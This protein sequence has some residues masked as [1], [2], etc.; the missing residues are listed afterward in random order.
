MLGKATHTI[1]IFSI[2]SIFTFTIL[3]GYPFLAQP[4]E[5]HILY[6]DDDGGANYTKIQ[7]A[8]DNASEGD[9]IYVYTGTYYENIRI[10][11]P[12]DLI[13]EEQTTTII[14]GQKQDN[15]INLDFSSNWVNLSGFTLQNASI[16][17][18]K[19]GININSDYHTISNNT[20]RDNR[21][22]IALDFWGHT[23]NIYHNTIVYNTCGIRVY[24]I[25]PN[26]NTIHHNNFGNN[27]KNA[28]DDSN[29]TWD[30][31]GEGNFWDD[32]T[33]ID[34]NNDGI[35]DTPY[36]IFGGTAQDR[37]PLMEP[38]ETPGFET[39]IFLL[40]LLFI[41]FILKKNTTPL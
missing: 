19:A 16:Q 32:Y 20:I 33:G 13:G 22:G 21:I 5:A 26:H 1:T 31:L 9:T 14:D 36:E 11:K 6:V 7:D 37:Y 39:F 2:L 40:A 41:I 10:D 18:N 25:I 27:G 29:S 15:V 23:C 12:I 3:I 30:V 17:P 24:S 35:G 38:I 8:I 28:Y 4:S 34:A